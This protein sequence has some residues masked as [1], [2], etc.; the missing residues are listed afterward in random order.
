MGRAN[1]NIADMQR[2]INCA[3]DEIKKV[4]TLEEHTSQ[5]VEAVRSAVAKEKEKISKC[6]AKCEKPRQTAAIALENLHRRLASLE[7]QL[8]NTPEKIWEDEVVGYDSE[9]D[10]IIEKVEKDNPKYL[11]LK[12][13]IASVEAKIREIEGARDRLDTAQET[14]ENAVDAFEDMLR[15]FDGCKASIREK[16]AKIEEK[17]RKVDDGLTPAIKAVKAY[18]EETVHLTPVPSHTGNYTPISSSGSA[19]SGIRPPTFGGRNDTSFRQHSDRYTTGGA[20]DSI[21]YETTERQIPGVPGYVDTRKEGNSTLLG[22][23]MAKEFDVPYESYSPEDQK[24][25]REW[26]RQ[27]KM[28]GYQKQHIIPLE[29]ADHPIIQKI[30]MGM[31]H[32]QNGIPLPVPTERVSALTTHEGYHDLYNAFVRQKLDGLDPNLSIMELDREVCHIQDTLR[33]MLVQGEPI[34]QIH[35]KKVQGKGTGLM[36]GGAT[37]ESLQHAYER[38]LRYVKRR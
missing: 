24:K 23:E 7:A 25:I 1:V 13:E 20:V 6:L 9:G 3:G 15:T 32:A 30:G 16:G 31:N 2:L 34:Y 18:L 8:A 28:S 27:G 29:M 4:K 33:Y 17:S 12:A 19:R 11:A 36:V 22:K 38:C 21:E 5:C 37:L 26:I 10:P 14:L 35:E